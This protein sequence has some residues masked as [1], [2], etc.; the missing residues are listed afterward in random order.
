MLEQLSM[1]TKEDSQLAQLTKI[2][3]RLY[4]VALGTVY[5]RLSLGVQPMI[6]VILY[7]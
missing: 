4:N 7:D 5:N 3:H 2:C 1:V 6:C